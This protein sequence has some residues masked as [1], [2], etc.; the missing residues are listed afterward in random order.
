MLPEILEPG[1]RA[2]SSGLYKVVH[3][4]NHA[5]PHC[6]TASMATYFRRAS[7]LG[8]S[9]FELA[10]APDISVHTHLHTSQNR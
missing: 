2:P 8:W 10:M 5:L 6:V 7:S 1:D 3:A 9:Q 4:G